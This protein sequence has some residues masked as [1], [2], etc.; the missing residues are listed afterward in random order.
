MGICII[1]TALFI[2]AYLLASI[3]SG[4]LISQKV[5]KLDITKV[6]SGNIG[7]T[8]V[9]REVGIRWGLITLLIDILK[10]FIPVVTAHYLLGSSPEIN[11][12]LKGVIG[13]SA[14][15]G[16]QFPIYNRFKGGK[17]VATCLGV[18]L[19]ISPTSC[20]FSVIIFLI[21]V[22]L[23]RYI[24]LGSILAVITMP[25]WLYSMKHSIGVIFFSI[26][27]SFLITFQHRANIQRL[28][29]GTERKWS[30]GSYRSRSI[31]R[32]RSSSE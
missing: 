20:L 4:L 24:S 3:P 23:W 31:K 5:K 17:G 21:S 9:A 12:T 29:Q 32:P 26:I 10:G 13:I 19:A 22:S 18:I 28:I 15:M 8:N 16:H 1:F 11:E 6:G 14:L 25:F 27:M 30:T 2:S 7:A